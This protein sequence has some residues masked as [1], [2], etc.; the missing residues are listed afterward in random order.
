MAHSYLPVTSQTSGAAAE[1]A[2]DRKTAKCASLTQ[3]YSFMAIAAETM[4]A[5]KSDGME[6]LDDLR[7]I[8]TQVNDDN[9]EKAFLYQRL[10][11]MIPSPFLAH[12]PTQPLGTIF[13]RSILSVL[14]SV[15]IPRDLYYRGYFKNN[16]TVV[17]FIRFIA[18]SSAQQQVF[19]GLE[20][21]RIVT[22]SKLPWSISR[23]WHSTWLQWRH[24]VATGC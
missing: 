5:I 13:S 4:G 11:V 9:R 22:L 14:T 10:F 12:L 1:A 24:T 17:C 7:R 21:W 6:F 19:L 23:R 15:F 16:N 20:F 2:A 18:R 3:V 8:I